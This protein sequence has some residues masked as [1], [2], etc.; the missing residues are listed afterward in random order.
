MLAETDIRG[1]KN[2]AKRKSLYSQ[3]QSQLQQFEEALKDKEGTIETLER[4]LVQ[5]GIKDKVRE[6]E[7]AIKKNLLQ[8]EA[9]QKNLRALMKG[10]MDNFRK[11]LKRE[12]DKARDKSSATPNK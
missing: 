2:I 3:M 7:V 11:D 5:A 4:Q 12:V 8:S 1:K 10:E 6:G 9:E